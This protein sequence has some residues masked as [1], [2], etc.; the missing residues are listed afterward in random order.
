MLQA[1]PIYWLAEPPSFAS[2]TSWIFSL[3]KQA[4]YSPK[5]K[6]HRQWTKAK[7]CKCAGDMITETVI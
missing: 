3:S 4:R 2:R 6:Q 1:V 5:H 7:P